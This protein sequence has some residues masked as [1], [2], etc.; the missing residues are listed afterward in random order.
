R[1]APSCSPAPACPTRPGRRTTPRS[2]GAPT[3]PSAHISK[4]VVPVSRPE[5][6]LTGENVRVRLFAA[7][8]PPA[9]ELSAA[10]VLAA[11][12]PPVADPTAEALPDARPDKRG[13]FRRRRSTPE[14][15][16]PRPMLTLHPTASL[17]LPMIKFGNLSA[18]DAGR[19]ADEMELRAPEWAAP[20]LR[21]AGGL[22]LQSEGRTSVWAKLS[23]DLD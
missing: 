9:A 3:R 23:G 15:R 16:Q 4:S 2:S 7:L 14:R 5:T 20:R 11:Q 21:L 6:G 13:L 10:R 12:V 22:V 1:P 18:A 8:V 19:L 17:H